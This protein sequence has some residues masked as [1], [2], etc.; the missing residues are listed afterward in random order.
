MTPGLFLA[1]VLVGT[2]V[3]LAWPGNAALGTGTRRSPRGTQ[4]TGVVLAAAVLGAAGVATSLDGTAPLLAAIILASGT[5]LLRRLRRRRRRRLVD[6]TRAQV[7]AVCESLTA[8]IRAGVMP[9]TALAGAAQVWSPLA[10]VARAARLG[11]DVPSQLRVLAALPGAAQVRVIAAAWGVSLRTG[12]GMAATL[13]VAARSLRDH[14]AT[15]D[16]V[17]SEIAAARATAT[18]LALL[19][20][21]ILVLGQGIGGDA[22]GFLLSSPGG[23]VCLASGVGLTHLGLAWLD[24]IA[25]S[26][27]G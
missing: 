10:P 26:V 13:D 4:G 15:A 19:P 9:A 5:D 25:D 27:Q 17:A 12:A 16:V 1:A 21:G 24:A 6:Q 3:L 2:V 22:L 8:D 18:V 11:A 14:R 20:A 23:L 7:L